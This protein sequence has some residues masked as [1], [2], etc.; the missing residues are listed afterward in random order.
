MK[1]SRFVP[2][3]IMILFLAGTALSSPLAVAAPP[4]LRAETAAPETMPAPE[5]TETA[6]EATPTPTPAATAEA[7]VAVDVAARI[8]ENLMTDQKELRLIA[9]GSAVY[10][11]PEPT[12]KSTRVKLKNENV[13]GLNEM[14]VIGEATSP[15]GAQF[16]HV[17]STFSRDAGYI[18]VKDAHESR[19]AGK[20]TPGYAQIDAA[21]CSLL[22][23]PEEKTFV[24]A[25]ECEHLVRILGELDG[26]YYVIT[27]AGNFGYVLPSQ[28][29]R[30]TE[31]QLSE[32][33]A[34]AEAPAIL[35]TMN[36][37]LTDGSAANAAK[38]LRAGADSAAVHY[39]TTAEAHVARQGF[40]KKATIAMLS[41]A[42][43][44][45]ITPVGYEGIAFRTCPEV[46]MLQDGEDLQRGLD[47]NLHG[48]LYSDSP[49]TSVS[50]MMEPVSG[51]GA[52][53]HQSVTFLP[54]QNLT[55]YSLTSRDFEPL[56]KKFDIKKLRAGQYHFTLTATSVSH[57]EGVTLVSVD[58]NIEQVTRHVLTQNKFDDNYLDAVEFFGNNTD[59]FL[60]P[61]YVGDGRGIGTD[62]AWREAHI[63][64]SSL[65]R[66]NIYAVPNFEEANHYLKTTYVRVNLVN[67][68]TG[69]VTDGVTMLLDELVDK[70]CAYVPRFQSN[71]EYLSHHTLGT[72]IDV[73]DNMYPNQNIPRNH[74]LIGGEV[75]NHLVY[76]GIKTDE[77]GIK[78]YD[79]TYDGTYPAKY[80]K[81]PKSILNYLVYELAFFRAGF[82]WGFY[83][84]TTCDA[85]HFML[86]ENDRNRHMHT[87]I[88][89][90]KVYG[91]I[92]PEWVYVPTPT[93]TIAPSV[94]PTA[95]VTPSP[96]ATPAPTPTPKK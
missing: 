59:A 84:E 52:A 35:E 90:R 77:S 34:Q 86:T 3:C 71:L 82:E 26:Y 16:Y 12:T 8:R 57:P 18:L 1:L 23:E 58:C 10:I 79:F 40:L 70:Y 83:Y 96:A 80:K 31:E 15:E 4:V 92:D 68:R 25:T 7:F 63:V 66:V 73:N 72:A 42:A 85:M 32:R 53:I 60:F 20:G 17:R 9:V 81:V 65:G 48:S 46:P 76:N 2:N 54:E 38:M 93:P 88:G 6:G 56:D 51:E 64:P 36:D 21:N 91:Y 27:E 75:K 47:F 33:L 87:D 14:I 67:V 30:I 29:T 28:V 41:V 24:I 95:G 13:R 43:G 39:W 78:Y 61:Y 45:E 94:T 11:Y 69:V 37:P 50:A 49:I 74:D 89:L 19:L 55:A 62:A 5:A 44:S 22:K